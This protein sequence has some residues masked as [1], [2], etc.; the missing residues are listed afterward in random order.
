MARRGVA[1]SGGGGREVGAGMRRAAP[2]PER[3]TS[4]SVERLSGGRIACSWRTRQVCTGAAAPSAPSPPRRARDACTREP[5]RVRH[6]CL[7]LTWQQVPQHVANIDA[8]ACCRHV[9]HADTRTPSGLA[10]RDVG[11]KRHIGVDRPRAAWRHPACDWRKTPDAWLHTHDGVAILTRSRLS[12]CQ[13]CFLCRMGQRW[14]RRP[15]C[16]AP[17]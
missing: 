4:A 2:R 15:A 14:H 13:S 17:A 8:R 3:L 6:G 1:I 16:G 11:A 9:G 10:E 7:G 5:S 12:G